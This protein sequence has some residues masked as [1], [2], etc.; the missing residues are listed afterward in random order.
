ML[1]S[2]EEWERLLNFVK[3]EKVGNPAHPNILFERIGVCHFH[4]W[5]EGVYLI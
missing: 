1:I 2:L 3:T 5:K 4:F